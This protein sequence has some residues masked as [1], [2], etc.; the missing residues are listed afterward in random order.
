MIFSWTCSRSKQS[1]SEQAQKRCRT[2]TKYTNYSQRFKVLKWIMWKILKNHVWHL[3]VISC[4]AKVSIYQQQCCL[5]GEE[6]VLQVQQRLLRQ[7]QLLLCWDRARRRLPF[8]QG[9]IRNGNEPLEN[10]SWAQMVFLEKTE[11]IR[12]S[13]VSKWCCQ[14]SRQG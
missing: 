3:C 6:A 14:P 9:H 13:K 8:R 2:G 10:R 11:F 12:W 1:H 7:Q 5:F 4:K